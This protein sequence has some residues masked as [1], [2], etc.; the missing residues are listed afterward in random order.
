MILSY[1][2][3]YKIPVR[4]PISEFSSTPCDNKG[5]TESNCRE[6]DRGDHEI[7]ESNNSSTVRI[8]TTCKPS[9]YSTKEI[10][11]ILTSDKAEEAKFTCRVQSIQNGK[12][13]SSERTSPEGQLSLQTG[14]KR[15]LLFSTSSQ[16]LA[17]VCKTSMEGKV[18]PVCLCF[19]LASAQ[20]VFTKLIKV[21]T[22]TLRRH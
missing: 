15:C 4:N 10:L 3:S 11:E 20:R 2:E 22:A 19:G 8:R 12:I 14:Y 5:E 21:P 17:K 1:V 16:G 6:R 18:I 9:F 13:V 7:H